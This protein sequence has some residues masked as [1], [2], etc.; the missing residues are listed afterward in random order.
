MV[1]NAGAAIDANGRGSIDVICSISGRVRQFGQRI[2]YVL[3]SEGLQ[4]GGA[5]LWRKPVRYRT[6]RTREGDQVQ[7]LSASR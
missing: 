2:A 7:T 5:V 4:H 1:R 3:Q 6:L